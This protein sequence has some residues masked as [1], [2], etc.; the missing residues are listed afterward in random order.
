MCVRVLG[1]VC[2]YVGAS[3]GESLWVHVFVCVL[4]ACVVRVCMCATLARVWLGVVAC[5][6]LRGCTCVSA[7][8]CSCIGVCGRVCGRVCV[9]S[10]VG[11]SVD[12]CVHVCVCVCWRVFVRVWVRV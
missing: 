7:C 10:C 5:V 8:E 4:G 12:S 3:V 2:T 11:A 9:V 6:C 1:R